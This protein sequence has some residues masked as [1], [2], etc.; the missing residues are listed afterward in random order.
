MG[1]K[2]KLCVL[3]IVLTTLL[4]GCDNKPVTDCSPKANEAR[5]VKNI[6]GTY[7]VETFCNFPHWQSIGQGNKG[8]LEGAEALYRAISHNEPEI[9]KGFGA[10]VG[11]KTQ[12]IVNIPPKPPSDSP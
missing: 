11:K 3:V 7:T 12:K 8:T 6:D 4:I 5:I 9:V 10:I 1:K 2:S